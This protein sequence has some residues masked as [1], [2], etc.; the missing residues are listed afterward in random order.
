MNRFSVK[1]I[2]VY[3]IVFIGLALFVA[4]TFITGQNKGTLF[5]PINT[6]KSIFKEARGIH[7]GT[8]VTIHGVRTGNVTNLKILKNGTVEITF[9]SSKKHSF[10]INESSVA[11]LKVQGALGDRY[12]AIFTKDLTATPLPSR[13]PIPTKPSVDL[14]TLLSGSSNNKKS[15]QTILDE[16]AYFVESINQKKVVENIN[17]ILSEKNSR[18][19]SE[20]L[21]TLKV[22]MRK[23]NKGEGTLGALVNDPSLYRRLLILLGKKPTN[24]MKDL[25]KD[26]SND[27]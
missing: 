11:Q 4:L 10:M 13:S 7:V 12:I 25:S 20:I 18:D 16:L 9:I 22:I 24:Y 15:V 5:K 27:L 21:R 14:L 6:Y 26:S 17:N 1:Q 2:I 3:F 23:I 8:E 19:L